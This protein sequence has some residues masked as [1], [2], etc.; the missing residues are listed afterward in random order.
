MTKQQIISAR[1][2]ALVKS[3]MDIQKAFDSVIGEGAYKKLAHEVYDSLR[4][5]AGK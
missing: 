4:A 2:I 3:G 5:K 1:I